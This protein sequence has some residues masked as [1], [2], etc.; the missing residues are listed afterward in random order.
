VA[1]G[2]V[3][4]GSVDLSNNFLPG[5]ATLI[6]GG[7]GLQTYYPEPPYMLSA[8]TAW[9]VLNTTKPPMSDP[10][11]RRALAFSVDVGKIVNVVYGNIVTSANP[12]GLLPNWDKY[13]DQSVV[14]ELGFTYD[15]DQARTILADAGYADVDGDGFVE[16]PDGS[17]IELSLI[18]PNGWTDWM[19]SIK[20]IASS[21]KAVGIH[22]TPEFPDYNALVDARNSGDYDMVINNDRQISNT[23][24]SYYDYIFRLPIQES[25]TTTN[26]GRYENQEAW[27][28]VQQLDRTP[29]DDLEGMKEI[30]SELQRIQLTDMPLIPLWYNGMW[31]QANTSVWTNWP[32]AAEGANHYLPS[33]WRGY[34]QMDAILMLA[35]L[36][37]APTD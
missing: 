22:V 6:K 18:V 31:A 34:W 36:E 10:A 12:T 30:I 4:Q 11:F 17:E 16:A 8:N 21:A 2:L 1:L 15:P 28:L 20:V 29:V 25:Q 23:P 3:L 35:E 13:I 7:Y 9:L 26:F 27:D 24:W 32:S 19:E 33:T 5:I 14:D 37:P